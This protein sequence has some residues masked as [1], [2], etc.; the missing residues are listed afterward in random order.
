MYSITRIKKQEQTKGRNNESKTSE[1]TVI[2]SNGFGKS[3]V[4]QLIE[5][6]LE[7]APLGFFC[8]FWGFFDNDEAIVDCLISRNGFEWLQGHANTQVKTEMNLMISMVF[9]MQILY[10]VLLPW[11][12]IIRQ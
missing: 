10:C 6:V 5:F 8:L 2:L 3:L 1:T 7:P 11:C 4:C 9:T 12:A